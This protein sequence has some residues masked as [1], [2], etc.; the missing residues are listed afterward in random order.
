MGKKKGEPDFSDT[1]PAESSEKQAQPSPDTA[2]ANLNKTLIKQN[3]EL[4]KKA[5]ELE[6]KISELNDRHMRILAEFDNYKKRTLR[7]K[8]SIVSEVT[9]M[10][11]EKILPVI[12]NL[13]LALNASDSD[14]KKVLDGIKL[15]LKQFGE[16]LKTMNV[17]EIDALG[18]PFDPNLHNAVMHEENDAMPENVVSEVF[19]KGYTLGGRVVPSRNRKSSKLK[20]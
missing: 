14:E 6:I 19:R 9:G 16:I 13:E 12:D 2:S 4:K 15:I 8:E 5:E 18:K 17:S 7:E 20:L 11:V 1:A 3:E 10:S